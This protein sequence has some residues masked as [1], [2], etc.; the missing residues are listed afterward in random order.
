MKCQSPGKAVK[1]FSFL[2]VL[3]AVAILGLSLTMVMTITSTAQDN[4]L[5]AEE[6]WARQ[7]LISSLTEYYL[8]MGPEADLPDNLLPEGFSA[9]CHVEEVEESELPENG[10]EP[11]KGWILGRYVISLIDP[12]GKTLATNKVEKL[13]REDDAE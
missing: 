3:V 8:L 9:T 7:H 4:V 6:R 2:E 11:N 10:A 12:N 1:F 5:R 13:I